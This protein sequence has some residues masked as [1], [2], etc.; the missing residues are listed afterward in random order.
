M[1]QQF[2]KAARGLLVVFV[3]L[4]AL[5]PL[6]AELIEVRILERGDV[7]GGTPFGASG[8]YEFLRGE[9]I[10]EADPTSAERGETLWDWT[11][12]ANSRRTSLAH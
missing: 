10:Y 8:G 7:L 11:V 3:C 4:T 5:F 6:K 12:E 2:G 1:C 9:L